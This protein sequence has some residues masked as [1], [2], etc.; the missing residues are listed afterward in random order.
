MCAR[1]SAD[2]ARVPENSIEITATAG[3][4]TTRTGAGCF[5]ARTTILRGVIHGAVTAGVGG[6]CGIII[7]RCVVGGVGTT[8][9][10][11]GAMWRTRVVE[12]GHM[13]VIECGTD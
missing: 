13:L 10:V 5:T 7:P 3:T 9:C 12:G 4:T 1:D 2:R 8:R 6:H 11:V